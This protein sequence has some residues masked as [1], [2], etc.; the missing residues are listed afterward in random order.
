MIYNL[1]TMSAVY[2]IFFLLGS[3]NCGYSHLLGIYVISCLALDQS[4]IFL[5]VV[6]FPIWVN[7]LMFQFY[8]FGLFHFFIFDA[9]L[10]FVKV[11]IVS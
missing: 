3:M 6:V 10:C 9:I 11:L 1:A 8:N 5:A 7:F 4:D 2:M